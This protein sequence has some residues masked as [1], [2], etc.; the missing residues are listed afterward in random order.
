MH[1]ATQLAPHPVE[2][3]SAVSSKNI[4]VVGFSFTPGDLHV[5][6]VVRLAIARVDTLK[7]LIIAN[8]SQYDRERIRAVFSRQLEQ[9][10]IVR[11]Y[12]DLRPFVGALPGC[13]D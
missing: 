5:Q 12:D 11:Q 13:L 8:P 10:V 4:A 6:A 3:L 1:F 7:R 9:N 2:L